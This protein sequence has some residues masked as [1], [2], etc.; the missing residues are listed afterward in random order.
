MKDNAPRNI[1]V[2][3]MR[4]ER[5]ANTTERKARKM[6]SSKKARV[7]SM[8]PYSIQMLI[9]TGETGKFVEDKT[10]AK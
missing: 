1:L 10:D 5:L 8:I 7:Y 2:Y 3:N 6:V 9:A 4:G